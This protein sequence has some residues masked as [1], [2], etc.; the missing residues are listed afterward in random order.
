[1]HRLS[2]EELR[3]VEKESLGRDQWRMR[4]VRW[5]LIAI[6][7]PVFLYVPYFR[8]HVLLTFA[9]SGASVVAATYIVARSRSQHDPSA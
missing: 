6:W 9:F 7:V 2:R 1:M 4:F 3:A 8:S 5:T